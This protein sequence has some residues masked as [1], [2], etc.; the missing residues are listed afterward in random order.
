MWRVDADPRY[1]RPTAET[2]CTLCGC[3]DAFSVPVGHVL[4]YN[5]NDHALSIACHG[6][7]EAVDVRRRSATRQKRYFTYGMLSCCVLCR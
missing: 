4:I 3:H 1:L 6:R 5:L 2:G 7:K